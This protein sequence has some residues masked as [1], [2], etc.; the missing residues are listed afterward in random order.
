MWVCFGSGCFDFQTANLGMIEVY[1][2]NR[3][4]AKK[5]ESLPLN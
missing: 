4:C 1:R 3:I 5:I 2:K